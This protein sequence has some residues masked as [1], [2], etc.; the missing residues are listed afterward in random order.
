MAGFFAIVGGWPL[1]SGEPLRI[2]SLVVA[3]LFAAAALIVPRSLAVANRAWMRFG[4]LLHAIVSPLALGI[5][6]VVAVLPTGLLMRLLGKRP[7][8]LDIDRSA[9]SYWVTRDPP[10]PDPQTFTNQF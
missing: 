9:N 2:W 4:E 7:L 6:F 8:S 5:I 3:V 1:L 10:G